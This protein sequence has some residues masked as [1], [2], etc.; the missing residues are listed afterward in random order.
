MVG[1][2][3]RVT[4]YTFLGAVVLAVLFQASTAQAAGNHNQGLTGG[5][6]IDDNGAVVFPHSLDRQLGLMQKAG[7]GWVRINFRL[8]SCYADWTSIGCNGKTALQ[9]Y[10]QLVA[11]ASG[12]G[13]KVLGLLSNE[14]WNGTQAVWQ[15]NN[16]EN[17]VLGNGDNLYL[18]TFSQKA[19]LVL[20]GHFRSSITYWEVWNE[21]NAWSANPA[22][23]VYTGITYIYPSNFAW[24]LRHVYADT[25]TAGLS[26]M[27]FVSGGALGQNNGGG[28][29]PG[30]DYLRSTYQQG[31]LNAG[32]DSV[33]ATYGSYPL[34]MIAQ[35]LYIDQN[36]ATNAQRINQFL[37]DVRSAYTAYEGANTGKK[38]V[39]TEFGWSTAA[40]SAQ[41]QAN[42]LKTAYTTFGNTSYV[43]SAYWNAAQDI[44][45]APG[46]WGLQTGGSV[47]DNYT[48]TP[49]PSFSSY[50][51]YANY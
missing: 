41:M 4:R 13:L 30:G 21:P 9:Q 15:A 38:T 32:W 27:Q 51:K 47:A 39:V 1:K 31:K 7:A 29:S 20:A 26:G 25:R 19:A 23:G 17:N 48:G 50:Q 18:Q 45:E 8:G 44:P 6:A 22:P 33:R 28:F 35:H 24:L 16:A 3:L 14:S 46:Y 40:V 43:F 37:S 2:T 12:H 10:D 49:K 11:D 34:D 5:W 36:G 42:N